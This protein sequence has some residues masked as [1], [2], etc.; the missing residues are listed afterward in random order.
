MTYNSFTNIFDHFILLSDYMRTRLS[1]VVSVHFKATN[2]LP[3][4][5]YVNVCLNCDKLLWLECLRP[6]IPNV[7]RIKL[8]SIVNIFF[9]FIF[10]PFN[11]KTFNLFFQKLN[12]FDKCLKKLNEYMILM[13][14]KSILTLL[15]ELL[16]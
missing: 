14:V 1:G 16:I 3:S 12:K 15:N 6:L 7:Y 2:W 13:I 10:N 4:M 11:E 9:T 5:S 8:K